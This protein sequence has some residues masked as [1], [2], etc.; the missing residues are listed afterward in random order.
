V[1]A[2][3]LEETLEKEQ[4]LEL[5]M[6]EV[7]LGYRSYGVGAAAFN[8]FG[9]SLNQL[10]P[11]R[12]G[13]LSPPAEGPENY[14]PQRSARRKA[15]SPPQPGFGRDGGAW[16]GSPRSQA[17]VAL[18]TDLVTQKAPGPRQVPGTA[19]YFVEEERLRGPG[20]LKSIG[21]AV[22]EGGYYIRTTLD[23]KLQ[24]AAR[25]AL[26]NGIEADDRRHGWRGP[27]PR[28]P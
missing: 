23:P 14:H 2:R 4:I 12:A 28:W 22:D 7:Y 13:L 16:G 24:T 11:E 19:D 25:I 15:L 10:T 21:E 9:K 6:N 18:A 8:Y 26:M 5:Y 17:R 1:L 20:R 27:W 3:R